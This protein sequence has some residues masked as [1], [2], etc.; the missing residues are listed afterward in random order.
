MRSEPA[1]SLKRAVL[2][3]GKRARPRGSSVD[4]DAR[5]ASALIP[6]HLKERTMNLAV[7]WPALF[8][9]GLVSLGAC[10]AFVFACEN[11]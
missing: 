7:W 11:I 4:A 5:L 6:Q 10:Y 1:P 9:L 8:A 2:R 3:A